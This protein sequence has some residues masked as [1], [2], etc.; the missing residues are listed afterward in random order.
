MKYKICD[1]VGLPCARLL[2]IR[3]YPTCFAFQALL[4]N[5]TRFGNGAHVPLAY[6]PEAR[7]ARLLMLVLC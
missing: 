5:H 6:V 4:S 3:Q 7:D 1:K 2:S